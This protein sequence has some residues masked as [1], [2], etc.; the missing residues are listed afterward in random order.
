MLAVVSDAHKEVSSSQGHSA[1]PHSPFQT[2]RVAGLEER[3]DRLVRALGAGDFEVLQ[4][5]TEEDAYSMH[6]VMATGRPPV[7]FMSDV[8]V[9][10]IASFMRERRTRG[11]QALWT[12]D[13]G[14]NVHFLVEP[15][16]AEDLRK[17]LLTCCGEGAVAV[18]DGDPAPRSLLE[19]HDMGPGGLV[20][21]SMDVA[22]L[23]GG[24]SNG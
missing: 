5:I 16:H 3:F 7:R 24:A 11:W 22:E 1:A 14:P 15:G 2:I 12:L 6:A 10:I 23:S 19:S 4:Q 21:G 17:F 18:L 8:T 9:E 13:A 20:I